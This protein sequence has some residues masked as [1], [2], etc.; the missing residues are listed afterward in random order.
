M[1]VQ[2]SKSIS[3]TV[4]ADGSTLKLSANN[5]VKF[6][7][8]GSDTLLTYLT[9]GNR[10]MTK[11]FDETVGTINTAAARTQAVTLDSDG[12]TLYIHSD[13]IIYL[14]IVTA[15][16]N[17]TYWNP[18]KAAP[19]VITVTEAASAINTA[20]GNTFR[21]VMQGTAVSRYI[22]NLFINEI[23]P[24]SVNSLPTVSATYK[25]LL[26]TVATSAVGSGYLDAA[27]VFTGGGVGAVLP[28]ATANIVAGEVVS[29]TIDTAGSNIT[30][31][32]TVTIT[33]ATGSNAA[34]VDV[35]HYTLDTLTLTDNG[36]N[37]NS[38]PTITFSAGTVT[39]TA[40]FTYDGVAQNVSAVAIGTAGSYLT[41][42]FP[43]TITIAGGAGAQILYDSKKTGFERL[44]VE[45]TAAA[46]QTIINAL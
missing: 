1:S 46:L 32:L 8:S 39:S 42:A 38:T 9:N 37:L 20:A 45:A 18:G 3:L 24:E 13:K 22:N 40:S 19:E 44:Q 16:T 7:A 15:G 23:D 25:L 36:S 35:I 10:L 43:P 28:T 33:S 17:I 31:D 27:V 26:E 21:V 29:I 30:D 34:A 6:Q 11:L 2:A 4:V 12:S 14:D 41:S 5:I